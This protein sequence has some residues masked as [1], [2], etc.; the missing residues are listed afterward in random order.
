MQLPEAAAQKF[1][2]CSES[3]QAEQ[4]FAWDLS[5]DVFVL[6]AA[7]GHEQRHLLGGARAHP[8]THQPTQTGLAFL[9]P[10][11]E[12]IPPRACVLL[13]QDTTAPEY[14]EMRL[15]FFQQINEQLLKNFGDGRRAP[16]PLRAPVT[17]SLSPPRRK[18]LAP[19]R[20]ALPLSACVSRVASRRAPD[21][22]VLLF[23]EFVRD[24]PATV[25]R[26]LDG[27]GVAHDEKETG[28]RV[29]AYLSV[30]DHK[31]DFHNA[32][33]EEMGITEEVRRGEKLTWRR[34][35]SVVCV[36]L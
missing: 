4:L 16:H 7:N 20:G 35:H 28:E 12:A 1:S 25:S 23:E 13:H 24:A 36:A 9:A 27:W 3:S 34:E 14:L 10:S 2:P 8:P 32:T 29:R 17:R 19:A 15:S 22:R 33:L 5:A 21:R 11:P 6:L 30:G 26:C 31:H 18:C